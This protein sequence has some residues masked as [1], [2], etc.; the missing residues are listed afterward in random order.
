[1]QQIKQCL[2]F[3]LFFTYNIVSAQTVLQKVSGMVYNGA[4]GAPI[5]GALVKMPVV[6]ITMQTTTDINGNFIFEQVPVGRYTLTVENLGFEIFVNR[7]L[8]INS[9]RQPMLEIYLVPIATKLPEV[10]I[11]SKRYTAED[12]NTHTI[13]VEQTQRYASVNEDVARMA[14]TFPGVTFV[15]DGVN[16]I[17]VNGYSPNAIQW[18]LEGIDILNPNHLSNGG[19]ISDRPSQSGG[20]ILMMSA[21]VLDNTKFCTSP[22]NADVGNSLGGLFDLSFRNGNSKEHEFTAQAGLIGIDLSAEGPLSKNK[23]SSYLFNYRY[24]TVGILS[25]MGVDFGG[26]KI[27]FQDF[28]FN[29]NFPLGHGGKLNV[30]GVGGNS[31]DNFKGEDD[32]SDWEIEKDKLNIKFKS[33]SGTVGASH[34]VLLG[35]N[36]L[37]KNTIAFSAQRTQREAKPAGDFIVYQP[38][39][40]LYSSNENYSFRTHVNW[41]PATKTQVS[42]GGTIKYAHDNFFDP[43]FILVS[44][45]QKSLSEGYTYLVQPFVSLSYFIIPNIKLTAGLHDVYYS[46]NNQNSIEPRAQLQYNMHPKHTIV[47][48]YGLCSQMQPLAMHYATDFSLAVPGY[49][50]N[51]NKNI[52]FTKAHQYSLAYTFLSDVNT[53]RAE[54]YYHDIFNVPVEKFSNS[55]Y[56]MLNEQEN[57]S[58]AQLVNKGTGINCGINASFQKFFTAKYYSLISASFYNT[59]YK[60]SD[61]KKHDTRFNGQYAFSAT[62]GYEVKKVKERKERTISYNLRA[63]YNGGYRESAVDENLSQSLG[64]TIYNEQH[65]FENKLKDYFR[66]DFRIVIRKNKIKCS[67]QWAL[68][69]QNLTGIENEQ[70]HYY[71]SV[72]KQTSVKKQL[73]LIPILSWRLEI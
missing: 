68:D 17:S 33:S 43:D 39:G 6:N 8:K 3:V 67:Q 19:T 24:S 40:D 31:Y 55:S 26:E 61:N 20:G 9:G 66:I 59:M 58:N 49:Y 38:Y 7:E 44:D 36:V 73:G 21:Q 54:V 50:F 16:H 70:Y 53:A 22:F 64:Y 15:N 30:F 4:T 10:E 47:A 52:E 56:S 34:K 71:D 29:V 48:S 18:R 35:K 23:N 62:G 11:K 51:P 65:A 27:A 28:S 41:L 60:G 45:V 25:A 42:V 69:I 37:W 12:A 32:S 46:L 13:T 72:K 1:M 63:I 57:F 2:L 14:Q 5:S